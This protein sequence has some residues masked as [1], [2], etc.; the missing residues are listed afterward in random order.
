MGTIHKLKPEVIG[1]LLSQ[2]HKNPDLSCRK[3][4]EII[5][6][7][8]SIKLSK[9]SVNTILKR[10]LL[11]SPVGRRNAELIRIQGE[12]EHGGFSI[13]QGIDSHFNLSQI[14]AEI[15]V[16]RLPGFSRELF[17]DAI[18]IVQALVIFKAIFDLTIEPTR[19]YENTDIWTL[20]GRRPT[21]SIYN[22]IMDMLYSSQLT[23]NEVVMDIRKRLIP[24]SGFRFQ[25][26]DNT[27]FFI[28]AQLQSIWNTPV[29]MRKC[30]ITYCKLISYINEF[31]DREQPLSIFNIQGANMYSQEVLDF[32]S[33]LNGQNISKRVEQIEILDIKGNVIE[34]KLMNSF[35]KRFFLLGFWPWQLEGLSEFERRPTDKKINCRDL[36]I[37]FY[38][39][40][41]E[42]DLSQHLVSQEVK[43][44]IILLKDEPLGAARIGILTN[45]PKES[46]HNYLYIKELYNWATPEDRYKEFTKWAKETVANS[47]VFLP[48]S[49]D[50]SKVA[51]SENYLE[52][53]F[54][55]LS[56]IIFYQFQQNFVP[57]S[58]RSW[59]P[60]KLK[61]VFLRQRAIIR[62][63][64]EF[65]SYNMLINNEL[66]NRA[67]LAF[68]CDRL[69][70]LFIVQK[71]TKIPHFFYTPKHP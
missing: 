52:N 8:F 20:V 64:K 18:D 25:L 28:D 69:N 17:T 68:I 59:S 40:I 19:C 4:A 11:S 62:R 71:N 15:F 16:E 23:V 5:S 48:N 3:L 13:L 34:T 65:I 35:E 24:V 49:F 10:E 9:S 60:L 55:I 51:N 47:T 43:Y 1:Y 22:K 30:Y 12:V 70:E 37:E 44:N 29:R 41:E 2:K 14:V 33:A 26:K 31:I 21:R 42:I 6:V 53:I 63:S 54:S 67:D 27:A 45:L 56:Q 66:C 36:G 46:I 38:Y 39:Q 58:C 7:K 61:D 50:F 57:E 32:I